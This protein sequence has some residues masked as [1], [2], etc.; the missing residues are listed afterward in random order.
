M[1]EPSMDVY[2]YPTD[3]TLAV[4]RETLKRWADIAR[5]HGHDGMRDEMYAL[6]DQSDLSIAVPRATL[7]GWFF[8]LNPNTHIYP[9][10][11]KVRQAIG[12]ILQNQDDL[13]TDSPNVSTSVTSTPHPWAAGFVRADV[14]AI[15][16]L[17]TRGEVED[18]IRIAL[19]LHEAGKHER[20]LEEMRQMVRD[21]MASAMVTT[22][23]GSGS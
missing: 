3:E 5:A 14:D 16:E 8:D 2:G 20:D 21:L 11:A 12:D 7:L 6:L 17:V 19:A 15:P 18:M 4:P 10:D 22:T 1:I 23:G 13:S 9:L